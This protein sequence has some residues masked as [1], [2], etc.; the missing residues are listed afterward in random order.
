MLW[1]CAKLAAV[2]MARLLLKKGAD[3]NL[4]NTHNGATPL[5][6][7]AEDNQLKMA[8][9]LLEAGAYFVT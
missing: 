3:I 6:K 1:H 9:F 2:E 7:A 5:I 8:E 4:K